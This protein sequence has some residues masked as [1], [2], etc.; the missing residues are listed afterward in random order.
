MAF[1]NPDAYG[2]RQCGLIVGKGPTLTASATISPTYTL[3]HVSG[4]ATINTISSTG[5]WP[6]AQV[7]LI[8]DT[9]LIFTTAGNLLNLPTIALGG[10]Y[11]FTWDGSHFYGK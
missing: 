3:H 2:T 4:S 11:Y 10:I 6:G 5:L 9:L 8:A 1:G 7:A